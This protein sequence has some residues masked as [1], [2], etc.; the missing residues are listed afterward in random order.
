MK[1]V[2]DEIMSGITGYKYTMEQIIELSKEDKLSIMNDS[3][4]IIIP[5]RFDKSLKKPLM[6]VVK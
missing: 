6:C 1:K 5:N 4:F 2:I 3:Y